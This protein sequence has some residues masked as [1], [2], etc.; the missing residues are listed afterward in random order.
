MKKAGRIIGVMTVVAVIFAAIIASMSQKVPNSEKIWDV[1]MTMG[2]VDAKNYFIIYSDI[3]CPY[4]VAFENAI[5][6]NEEAF[7]EYI[8]KNDILV[9]I[10]MSDFLF[11]YGEAKAIASKYSAE[12]AYCAKRE[13]KFWDYYNTA[14]GTVWDDYFSEDGKGAFSALNKLEKE[15][16]I[17]LGK[18]V[19]LGEEFAKCV[20]EDQTIKE[21]QENAAK[22]SKL[23]SGMPYFKFNNYISS[24]FDLSWGWD[25]V[26]MYFA[27]GLES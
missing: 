8:E 13:G 16:W 10:R 15:Y 3:A 14:I 23:A 26:L 19:G 25:H 4:C 21:I 1:E 22:T 2:N 24:G 7:Q 11:E 18:K 27:A 5:V 20:E 12:G 17:G 9:E 6:E